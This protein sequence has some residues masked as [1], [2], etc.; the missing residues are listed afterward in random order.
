MLID[1]VF[2]FVGSMGALIAFTFLAQ[3]SWLRKAI[4]VVARRIRD[5]DWAR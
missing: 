5:N 1:V 4:A 3:S 2:D